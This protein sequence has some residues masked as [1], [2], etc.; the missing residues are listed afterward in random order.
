MMSERVSVLVTKRECQPSTSTLLEYLSTIRATGSSN[1]LCGPLAGS[2]NNIGFE[3][4][5]EVDDHTEEW[6]ADS[7]RR[8]RKKKMNKHKHAKRRKLNRHRK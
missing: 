4:E 8:K 3:H 6:R 5:S 1:R 2:V 7:V